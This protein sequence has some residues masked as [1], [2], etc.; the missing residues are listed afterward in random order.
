MKLID[1]FRC[2]FLVDIAN[3]LPSAPFSLAKGHP[4]DGAKPVYAFQYDASKA[5]KL[6][7]LGNGDA[8]EGASDWYKLRTKEEVLKDAFKE[9]TRR[10]W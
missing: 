8:P 5:E 10:G 4:L 1:F 2:L 6:L 9:Y 7:H 3:S